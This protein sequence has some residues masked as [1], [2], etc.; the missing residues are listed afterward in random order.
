MAKFQLFFSVQGIGGSSTGPDPENRVGDQDIESPGMPVSSGLQ[1]PGEPGLCRA[2]TR[3]TSCGVFLSK[4][5]SI[6]PAEMS[7]IPR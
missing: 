7:N 4:C 6:T 3:H 2:T 5:P 1:V